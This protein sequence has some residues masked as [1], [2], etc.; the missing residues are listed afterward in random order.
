MDKNI[1]EKMIFEQSCLLNLSHS[2][3]SNS[4]RLCD[5]NY[6]SFEDMK[7]D[8]SSLLSSVQLASQSMS[9]LKG[10]FLHFFIC[11]VVCATN[12]LNKHLSRNCCENCIFF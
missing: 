6:I 1:H 7:K 3:H 4:T 9:L 12:N 11:F 10:F 5:L 8:F 2:L